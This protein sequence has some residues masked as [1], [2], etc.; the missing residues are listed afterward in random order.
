MMKIRNFKYLIVILLVFQF[1]YKNIAAQ[2]TDKKIEK[3]NISDALRIGQ[4]RSAEIEAYILESEYSKNLSKQSLYFDNP[5]FSFKRSK[6]SEQ[7]FGGESINGN[8]FSVSQK[9]PFWNKREKRS[10]VL[11]KDW[12]TANIQ[13]N[14]AKLQTAYQIYVLAYSYNA[15]VEKLKL[16]KKRLER[17]KLIENYI[18]QRTFIA[19]NDK[20]RAAIVKNKIQIIEISTINLEYEVEQ[21][22][23]KLNVFLNLPKRVE[24]TA[25]WFN[26]KD[27]RINFDNLLNKV[28]DNNLD[29]KKQNSL[30]EKARAELAVANLEKYPDLTV[31]AGTIND[32]GSINKSQTLSGGISFNIPL[33]NRNQSGIAATE[34]KIKSEQKKYDFLKRQIE[35]ETKNVYTA[36]EKAKE[37]ISIISIN[38]ID[39][40]LKILKQ[41]DQDFKTGTLDFIVYLELDVGQYEVMNQALE[42]Q[43][44]FANQYGKILSLIGD[45]NLDKI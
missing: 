28:L 1:N 44:N 38:R 14:L 23:N 39:E 12:N 4:E 18:K 45:F 40:N 17:F 3:I 36:Y 32:I 8:D 19:P 30:I 2:E 20:A 16:S 15:T 10:D 29:L 31:S 21:L 37:A 25:P 22:W 35:A 26:H 5:T 11:N 9:I 24:I 34:Y 33:I 7:G 6:T 41:A 42:L 27:H 13:T 43:T